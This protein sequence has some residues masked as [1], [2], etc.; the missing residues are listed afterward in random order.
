MSTQKGNLSGEKFLM[1]SIALAG[2]LLLPSTGFALTPEDS[3]E[4]ELQEIEEYGELNDVVQAVASASTAAVVTRAGI[5]TVPTAGISATDSAVGAPVNSTQPA[6]SISV[7][8][9]KAIYVY[10]NQPVQIVDSQGRLIQVIY[11]VRKK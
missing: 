11:L 6:S 10:E 1:S 4:A 9:V 2:A 3:S 8:P 5:G 7:V